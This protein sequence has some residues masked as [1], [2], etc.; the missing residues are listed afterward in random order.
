MDSVGDAYDNALCESLFTT[1]ECELMDLEEAAADDPLLSGCARQAY[2]PSDGGDT[3]TS[4]F[5][6]PQNRNNSTHS[7]AD[8]EC[9]PPS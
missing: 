6:R 8:F 4:A 1:L 3:N 7:R 9:Y 5:A 2:S